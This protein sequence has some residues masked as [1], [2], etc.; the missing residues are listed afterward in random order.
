MV[1]VNRGQVGT[2]VV[3]PRF[4]GPGSRGSPLLLPGE[5]PPGQVTSPPCC[6]PDSL[7]SQAETPANQRPPR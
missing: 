2:G 5:E 7:Q 6:M 1:K 4:P 3:A